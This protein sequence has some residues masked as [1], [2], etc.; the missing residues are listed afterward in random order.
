MLQ[1]N[2]ILDVRH[3]T[4][5]QKEVQQLRMSLIVGIW[6]LYID[7][8]IC[9]LYSRANDFEIGRK[10]KS[11]LEDYSCPLYNNKK[12]YKHEVILP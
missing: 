12:I 3:A 4:Q 1:V 11:G 8:G 7:V 10:E 5:E 6:E 2:G 9:G